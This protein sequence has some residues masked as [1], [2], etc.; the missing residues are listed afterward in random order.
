MIPAGRHLG[1]TRVGLG[2]VWK[3]DLSPHRVSH[4]DCL[5]FQLYILYHS[6]NMRPLLSVSLC[7]YSFFFLFVPQRIFHFSA[8]AS[9]SLCRFGWYWTLVV[10]HSS[11]HPT[12]SSISRAKVCHSE[13]TNDFHQPNSLFINCDLYFQLYK[14]TLWVIGLYFCSIGVQ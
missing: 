11:K 7:S 5:V 4:I 2:G 14:R 1:V 9:D 10:L 6:N 8:G 12:E 3:V 13:Q